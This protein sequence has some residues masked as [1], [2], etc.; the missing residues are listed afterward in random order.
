[1]SG[2]VELDNYDEDGK[3]MNPWLVVLL[4]FAGVFV[5][6]YLMAMLKRP[7]SRY[8]SEINKGSGHP[9][10]WRSGTEVP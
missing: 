8:E 4:V 5:L 2:C 1:M 10:N 7:A 6:L 3:H 9:C